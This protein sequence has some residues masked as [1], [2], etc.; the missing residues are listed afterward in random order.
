VTARE[1]MSSQFFALG[2]SDAR[3]GHPFRADYDKWDV[4][5]QWNYERGRV[6]GLL[7]PRR[8]AL[9]NRKGKLNPDA[10][11]WWRWNSQYIR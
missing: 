7:A 8:V 9:K 4:D 3:A 6:W 2:V 1:I 10:V 11:F 5:D